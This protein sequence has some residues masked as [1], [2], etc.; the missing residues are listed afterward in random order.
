[1]VITPIIYKHC[2]QAVLSAYAMRRTT[3]LSRQ[4]R[5]QLAP[6][7]QTCVALA[8]GFHVNSPTLALM[9]YRHPYWSGYPVDAAFFI[10]YNR[11]ATHYHAALI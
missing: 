11:F 9:S 7:L 2:S 4:L 1:M 3:R 10:D 8:L 5:Y 6:Q